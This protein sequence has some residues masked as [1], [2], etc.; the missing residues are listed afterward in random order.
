VEKENSDT[1]LDFIEKTGIKAEKIGNVTDSEAIEI[2][3]KKRKI[4][5]K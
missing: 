4:A 3:Y 2:L 1:A 5:L